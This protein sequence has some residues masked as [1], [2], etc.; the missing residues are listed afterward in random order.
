M[1][2]LIP[3]K[4]LAYIAGL[5]DGEGSV[6]IEPS[7]DRT[8]RVELQ[9]VNTDKRMIDFV[10][11]SLGIGRIHPT[12]IKGGRKKIL[13]RW[14]LVNNHATLVMKLLLPYL[15]IKKEQALLCIQYRKEYRNLHTVSNKNEVIRRRKELYFKVK[16][17]NH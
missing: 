14:N 10:K 5:V 6:L 9:I 15:V 7:S 4:E 13:W 1:N 3:E 8:F 16:E 11:E 2:E 12:P 17:L